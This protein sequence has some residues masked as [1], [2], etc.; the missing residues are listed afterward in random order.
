MLKEPTTEKL[1]ASRLDTVAAAWE[2]QQKSPDVT[3]LSFDERFGMLVDAEWLAPGDFSR[4]SQRWFQDQRIC[5]R[6]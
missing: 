6:P 4:A 5:P 3:A 1:R 2:E